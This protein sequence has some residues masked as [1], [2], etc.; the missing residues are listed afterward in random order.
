MNDRRARERERKR[1]FRASHPE[2][3][4]KQKTAQA[5][6][7]ASAA[8]QSQLAGEQL[9][10][11]ADTIARLHRELD[12]ARTATAE[13]E[14]RLQELQ[15]E[16]ASRSAL[17]DVMRRARL[18]AKAMR[19]QVG[20]SVST[21]DSLLELVTPHLQVLTTHSTPRKHHTPM[22]LS[23][24]EQLFL[25]LYW[26][27]HYPTNEGLAVFSGL[28]RWCAVVVFRHIELFAALTARHFNESERVKV[29]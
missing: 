23:D 1:E 3:K 19:S 8:Q 15:Q 24:A 17:S 9:E 13:A 16:F 14:Q 11:D 26:C 6:R 2:Y 29:H 4:H 12:A 21:F 18:S 25:T 27:R 7:R 10:R 28:D 5:A 20:M 22:T